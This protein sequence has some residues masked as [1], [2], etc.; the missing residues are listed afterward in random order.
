MNK[1]KNTIDIVNGYLI[2]E[3][4]ESMNLKTSHLKLS[5]QRRK[6]EWKRSLC[7]I[8]DIIKKLKFTWQLQK[9][10]ERKKQ[11]ESLFK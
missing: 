1:M 2:K 8:W 5:S 11:I 3:K 9:D 4:N 10:V 6:K 7:D